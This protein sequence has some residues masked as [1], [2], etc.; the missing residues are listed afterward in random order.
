MAIF[1]SE[2]AYWLLN[3]LPTVIENARN[4]F[5]YWICGFCT[6][7]PGL[8]F[9]PVGCKRTST[10]RP[11][12]PSIALVIKWKHTT[13]CASFSLERRGAAHSQCGLGITLGDFSEQFDVTV[14]R[15]TAHFTAQL[16]P[17]VLRFRW[18]LPY[19]RRRFNWQNPLRS[20]PERL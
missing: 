6:V 19:R 11:Q 18:V 17:N 20:Q 13:R 2:R 3:W 9:A 1:K 15:R 4:S 7:G 16:R 8:R 12:P 10:G 5:L 14:H